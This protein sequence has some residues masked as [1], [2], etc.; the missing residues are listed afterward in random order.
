MHAIDHRHRR[1]LRARRERPSRSRAAKQ[2]VMNSR[3]LMLNLPLQSRST[4]PSGC[5]KSGRR[6][7]Q[8]DL[9]C[10]DGDILCDFNGLHCL[11]DANGTTGAQRF[12]AALSNREQSTRM[13]MPASSES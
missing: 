4:A 9:N 11:P 7:L 2:R 1:L 13:W 5:H 8:V 10:S 3:R 12:L 6:V